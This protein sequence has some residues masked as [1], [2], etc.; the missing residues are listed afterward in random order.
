M[1]LRAAT[2]S[3][4]LPEVAPLA[5]HSQKPRRRGKAAI[6]RTARA[7]SQRHNPI[8]PIGPILT[9]NADIADVAV[10]WAVANAGREKRLR[11]E[12]LMIPLKSSSY[13]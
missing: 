8:R 10:N 13:K 6:R 7:Q 3:T 9:R 5:G 12:A 2:L 4:V 11:E 1:R